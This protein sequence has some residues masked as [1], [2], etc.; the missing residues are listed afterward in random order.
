MRLRYNLE[1]GRKKNK[2]KG[3]MTRVL[4]YLHSKILVDILNAESLLPS[5]DWSSTKECASCRFRK[6]V[7]LNAPTVAIGG[8]DT[9]EN[10]LYMNV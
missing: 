3:Q 2:A 6:M 9:A 1:E 4:Q 5:W 8:V 7:F 10:K